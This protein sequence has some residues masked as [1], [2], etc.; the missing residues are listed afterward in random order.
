MKGQ[1]DIFDFIEKPEEQSVENNPVQLLYKVK[2]PVL[3]CVNCVCQYCVNNVEEVWDKVHSDE[4][5]EPCFNCDEC[6]VFT[7]ENRLQR[8]SKEYCDKFVLSDYGAARN[9]KC[10]KLIKAGGNYG[11]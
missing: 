3:L 6:H 7:G 2:N 10:I 9:R 11:T 8:R 5:I 1:M 4:V